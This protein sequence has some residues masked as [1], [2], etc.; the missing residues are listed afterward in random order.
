M[1]PTATDVPPTATDVPTDVPPTDVPTE[2][3][4]EEAT[5]AAQPTSV[6][7]VAAEGALVVSAGDPIVLGSASGL[8]GDGIAPL[9]EDIRRGI[10]LALAARPTV[11]VDG[12]EFEVHSRRAGRPVLG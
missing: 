12:A 3:P 2:V 9:G 11:T 10:E 7:V 6:P 5:E 8:S 4:T 1:S